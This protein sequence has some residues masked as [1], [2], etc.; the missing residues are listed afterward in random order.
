MSPHRLCGDERGEALP[1]AILFVGVLTTI[2]IGVHVVLISIARTA[3]QSAADAAVAA[4]QVAGPGG[5]E[6]D[7]DTTTTETARQCQGL[8]G[9]RLALIRASSSV[10]PTRDPTVA[11]DADRGLVTAAV[12]GGTRSPVLGLVEVVAVSCGPLDDVR[13]YELTGTDPWQC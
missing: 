3:V 4:A 12:F 7:G 11:V 10:T 13:L 1:A 6:C 5:Q 2:L 8:A 9:A